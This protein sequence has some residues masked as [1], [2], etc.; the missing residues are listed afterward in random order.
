MS[1]SK[2]ATLNKFTYTGNAIKKSVYQLRSTLNDAMQ[3][4]LVREN[5]RGTKYT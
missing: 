4:K 3:L 1:E 2:S 5:I